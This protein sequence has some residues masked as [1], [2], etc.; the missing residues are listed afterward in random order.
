MSE[1]QE[2][3]NDALLRAVVLAF[4]N[5][6]PKPTEDQI[7]AFAGLLGFKFQEFETRMSEVL[8]PFLDDDVDFSRG[9]HKDTDVG[10]DH[11]DTPL[12]T[13]LMAFYTLVPEPEDRQLLILGVLCNLDTEEL[14]AK[15]YDVLNKLMEN[16][17]GHELDLHDIELDHHFEFD[18]DETDDPTSED[19]ELDGESDE[20]DEGD[21]DDSDDSGTEA[22]EGDETLKDADGDDLQLGI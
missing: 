13:F 11:L 22:D 2:E 16:P 6:I 20:S 9:I 1:P 19:G 17:A 15:T 7:H 4:T 3:S 8:T 12:E 14:E 18:E 5:F 10:L 21:G